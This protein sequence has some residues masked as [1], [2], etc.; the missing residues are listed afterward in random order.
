VEKEDKGEEITEEDR[1][2]LIDFYSKGIPYLE[3]AVT[4]GEADAAITVDS[5]LYNNLGVAYINVGNREKGEYYFKKAE[6]SQ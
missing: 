3:K 2:R 1:A 6:E 4:I 5:A